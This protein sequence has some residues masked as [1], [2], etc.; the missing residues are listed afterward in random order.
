MQ[1]RHGVG[2]FILVMIGV[3]SACSSNTPTEESADGGSGSST[4]SSGG[5]DDGGM[6]GDDGAMTGDEGSTSEGEDGGSPGSSSD[7]GSDGGN[8][9]GFNDPGL[10]SLFDGT[11]LGGWTQRNP[12]G[13]VAMNGVIHGTG[14]A[15]RGFLYTNQGYGSFRWIFTVRH[16]TG[17]HAP[18]V[19]VWGVSVMLDAMGAL[20]FQPPSGGSWDYRPGKNNGGAGY[21]TRLPHPVLTATAWNQCEL[22]A[23]ATTG[24]ARMACCTIPAGGSH[25]KGVE[26]LDFKDPT[27]TNKSSPIA[28]QVHNGGLIDE[29]KDLYIEANPAQD[30]LITTQ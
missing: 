25:C 23:N 12:G 7:G 19:L 16:V 26:V 20:Q 28:L 22:L 17:G 14:A 27:W 2:F 11:T 10:V 15:G 5:G 18:C 8:P 1:G 6:N 24:V 13:W 30:M 21:F 9:Y 29:Y 4:G 3:V